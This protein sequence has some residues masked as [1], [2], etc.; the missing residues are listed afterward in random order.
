[1]IIRESTL[2]EVLGW[3][4]PEARYL[5]EA[6]LDYPE[7]TGLFRIPQS[8]YLLQSTGHLN[9]VDLLICYNQLVFSTFIEAT[10]LNLVQELQGVSLDQKERLG[11]GLIVGINNVKFKRPIYPREFKGN[12]TIKEVI[13]KK[14]NT[15]YFFK[16]YYDFEES[17]AT[18][19][20]DLVLN[21]QH[22]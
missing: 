16:T 10:Q 1:M 9:A 19:E 20:I 18:G 7:A 4:K 13:P 6:E 17:K 8:V 15:L 11:R 2:E 14:G 5:Q 22:I 21:L 12:I 3:Y